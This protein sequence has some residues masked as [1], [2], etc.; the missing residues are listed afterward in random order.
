M[1]FYCSHTSIQAAVGGIIAL[2]SREVK[3]ILDK[4]E[5]IWQSKGDVADK[6]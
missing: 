2:A 4:P 6:Q 5:S 1:I 3:E